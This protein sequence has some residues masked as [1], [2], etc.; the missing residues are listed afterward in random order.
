M[1][2]RLSVTSIDT[3]F[4][5]PALWK[6]KYVDG[7]KEPKGPALVVGIAMHTA[8]E[9]HFDRMRKAQDVNLP[10]GFWNPEAVVSAFNDAFDEAAD[11]AVWGSQ[12]RTTAR[13]LGANA[14]LQLARRTGEPRIRRIEDWF[15]LPLRAGWIVRGKIDLV[16]DDAIID[17]KSQTANPSSPWR[18]NMDKAL[19][20]RQSG[21]YALGLKWLTGT[22][23]R[24]FRFAVAE[25]SNT[26]VVDLYPIPLAETRLAVAKVTALAVSYAIDRGAFPRR[27][28]GN[29]FCEYCP[30]AAQGGCA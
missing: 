10:Y 17:F 3:Y 22:Y 11:D 9:S 5:C 21:I 1:T 4:S 19:R 7:F 27:P 23:P 18:W 12:S 16:T 14:T 13:R 15:D 29:K 26:G 25:K 28:T 6:R 24:W 20:S 2:R 30:L 8:L